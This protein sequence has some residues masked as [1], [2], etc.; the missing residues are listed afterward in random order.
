MKLTEEQIAH[1]K[2]LENERGVLTADA[3]V[4]DAK[5]KTSPLHTLPVW[6]NWNK[7]EAAHAWWLECAREII[8]T[9]QIVVTTETATVSAPYYVHDP[10]VKGQGYRSVVAL[11]RD[12]ASA[13]QALIDELTRAAG[14]MT[15]AR[16]VAAALNLTDEIDLMI[17]QI[18]GLHARLTDAPAAESRPSA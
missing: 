10:D 4:E 1:V 8:R 11:Q 2:L 17:A 18:S 12:P 16:T 14:A 7:T 6:Q 5:N 13:R 3:L 15:R 9:V